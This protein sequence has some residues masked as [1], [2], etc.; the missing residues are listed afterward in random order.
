VNG[1]LGGPELR[2]GKLR[3]NSTLTSEHSQV[4]QK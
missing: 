4:R 1:Q 3:T 2:V